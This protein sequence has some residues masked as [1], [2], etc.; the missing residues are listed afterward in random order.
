MQ[1]GHASRSF[2]GFPTHPA[3]HSRPDRN[4]TC[5]ARIWNPRRYLSIPTY[6]GPDRDRTG[7]IPVT[8]ER[9][10]QMPTG[11]L[12]D[13]TGIEP[14]RSLKVSQW[15]LSRGS[16]QTRPSGVTDGTRTRNEL[17][18]NQSPYHLATA[19]ALPAGFEP[20]L[21]PLGGV[22]LST[23][24]REHQNERCRPRDSNPH[25]RLRAAV[26]E[27]AVSAIPPRR[28]DV[29]PGDGFEPPTR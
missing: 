11:P 25:A 22:R 3:Y 24:L 28:H 2:L 9:L 10:H 18:H 12:V 1:T 26:F 23:R 21:T 8:G 4:R 13:A 5:Y 27:T 15:E 20:A 14:A 29:V 16:N 7:L 6:G 19:T 17:D